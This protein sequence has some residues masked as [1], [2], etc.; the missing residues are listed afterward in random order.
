M[1]IND[2]LLP[3]KTKSS[4]QLENFANSFEIFEF[5]FLFIYEFPLILC[6]VGYC[7]VFLVVLV[8]IPV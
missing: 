8:V 4:L 6:K 2:S 1:I 7:F 3:L 5:R